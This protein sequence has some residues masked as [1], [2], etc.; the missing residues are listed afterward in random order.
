MITGGEC[1]HGPN[2]HAIDMGM[3]KD[4]VLAIHSGRVE[5]TTTDQYGGK[6]ILLDHGDGYCSLY[7]HLESFSVSPGKRIQQGEIIGISGNTGKG[8]KY[9]LHLAVTRKVNGRCSASQSQEVR[10]IFDESLMDHWLT[11]IR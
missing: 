4:P 5:T 7:L 10:M 1:S 11:K 6:Y 2:R 8:G 3:Y 9:H